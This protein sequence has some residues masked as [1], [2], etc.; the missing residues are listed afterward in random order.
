MNFLNH[1]NLVTIILYGAL[2]IPILSGI[3]RPF[4]NARIQHSLW[5][6]LSTL[7]LLVSIVLSVYFTRIVLSD[8][9]NIIL[10]NFYRWIPSARNFVASRSISVYIVFTFV[11]LCALNLILRILTIPIYKFLLVPLSHVL[12]SVVNF[13]PGF[14]RPIIGGLWQVPKALCSVLIF[15]LLL[16]AYS[17]FYTHTAVSKYI[18]S[19]T[20]YQFMEERVTDPLLSS[21][22]AKQ[23]P[24]ILND[25]FKLGSADS[26]GKAQKTLVIQ[27]FNGTTLKS[28]VRSNAEIDAA[29]KVIVGS[30]SND[31]EKAYLIYKWISHNITYD[32]NKAAMLTSNSAKI[33]SGAIVAYRTRTGVCFDYSC[34]Y[35]AMC[36]AVNVK[37][38]F[39]TGLGYSGTYWGDH[40][41][42]QVYDT[43]AKRWIN[44]DTTFGST[45]QNYFDRSNFYADHKADVVQGEW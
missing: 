34:L 31:R 8:D 45:G 21:S 25:S 37:V 39:I 17:G 3:I 16:S 7:E 12:S 15:S 24:V 35:V 30:S 41:W 28:A 38:R 32:D 9:K 19:S 36:R 29:A 6:L 26:L 2:V 27:Y 20:A 42:N 1:F 10:I 23:I 22:I 14:I 40:S 13:M 43:A 44:I 18:E 5:T 4:S 33:S 11:F